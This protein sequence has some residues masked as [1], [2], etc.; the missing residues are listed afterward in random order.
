MQARLS[1]LEEELA[2]RE[3]DLATRRRELL[4]FQL[5]YLAIVGTRL[6]ELDRVE[7]QIA[8]LWAARNPSPEARRAAADSAARAR[9]SREE[10][11]DDPEALAR[12]ASQPQPEIPEDLKKLFRQVAKAVHPDLAACE[13]ERAL[14]ERLMAEANAAYGAGDAA[15]LR[16]ILDDWQSRPEAVSGDGIGADLIRAIRA[17]A[18]IEA[19]LTALVLEIDLFSEGELAELH[20]QAA[21]AES[22]GRDLLRELADE[23]EARIAAARLR[24]QS[25]ASAAENDLG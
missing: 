14:R 13:D 11:G 9:A 18:A 19:R 16:A 6:T 17:V 5:R 3:L 2:D 1:D 15:R 12:A 10:L 7:A 21:Q 22:A 4:D 8:A 20:A 25:M 24:L 23:V